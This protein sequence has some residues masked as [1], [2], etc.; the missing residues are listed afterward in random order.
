MLFCHRRGG[1]SLTNSGNE[2]FISALD[3]GKFGVFIGDS[4]MDFIDNE[5][6]C[7]VIYN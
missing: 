4:I 5:C 3:Q 1:L 7:N 6:K 2:K